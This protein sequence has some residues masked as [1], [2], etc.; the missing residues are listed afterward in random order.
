MET[1]YLILCIDDDPDDI[2]MLREAFNVLKVRYEI[3]AAHN[4]EEGLKTLHQ[5]RDAN[6]LPCLIVLDINMPKMDGR[7]T[8]HAM[9]KDSRFADIP[10]VI[11]STSSSPLDK[12]FFS[13]K[14]VEY[15]VKPIDFQ[16]LSDVAC[17]F[18]KICDGPGARPAAGRD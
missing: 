15:F 17:A 4:G 9:R 5:L 16:K 13:R 2:S 10:V 3:V 11:F 14:A 18:L 1:N 12:L 8:F 7:E 6:N